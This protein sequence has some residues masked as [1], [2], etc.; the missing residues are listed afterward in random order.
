[1]K[2]MPTLPDDKA[3]LRVAVATAAGW[4]KSAAIDRC[5]N[6]AT[7]VR[8]AEIA[9]ELD[10]VLAMTSYEHGEPADEETDDRLQRGADVCAEARELARVG[11]RS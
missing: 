10:A 3:Q 11:P 5:L 1:M 4:I 2:H 9:N 6:D 7:L 8:G